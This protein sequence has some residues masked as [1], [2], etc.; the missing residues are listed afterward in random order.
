MLIG[1]SACLLGQKVRYDGGH[2]INRFCTNILD[3]YVQ[4]LPVCPEVE[5]GL[6]TPRNTIRL[7]ND[8]NQIPRLVMP[9]TGEDL[10]EKMTNFSLQKTRMLQRAGICGYILKKDS[11]SCGMARVKLHHG[12]NNL[13]SNRDGV[14]A[15]AKILLRE[16]P[17]LPVEEEGRLNDARLRENFITR[18]HAYDRWLGLM[19]SN[20]KRKEL[21]RFHEEYKYVLMAHNQAGAKR[22]GKIIAKPD[23][24]SSKQ[25][26][27]EAYMDEF[28]LVMKKPAS[29]KSHT[30]ALLHLMGYL[31]KYADSQDRELIQNEILKYNKGYVPLIVPIT[32]LKHFVEK[33]EIPYLLNQ[34]Y[35]KPHPSELMLLNQL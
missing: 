25:A 22:L 19:K 18:I 12:P 31:R 24:Y 11:P 1:V 4:W 3:D 34:V 35:L 32:L 26:W 23:D 28:A 14:G 16:M 15:F 21:I 2:K 30:N 33:F 20:W 17:H 8:L 27:A 9:K 7:E 5:I 29:K 6:G 13:A 10:T